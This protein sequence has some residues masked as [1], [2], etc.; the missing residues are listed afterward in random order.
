[1]KPSIPKL[2]QDPDKSWLAWYGALTQKAYKNCQW[3]KKFEITIMNGRFLLLSWGF[4]KAVEQDRS[5]NDQTFIGV[6][7]VALVIGAVMVTLFVLVSAEL[8]GAAHC[9]VLQQLL[10]ATATAASTATATA[11]TAGAYYLREHSAHCC[12]WLLQLSACTT[13]DPHLQH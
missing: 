1:V 4:I 10:L 13:A 2:S 12:L 9:V 11:T 8:A 5:D 7:W 6:A 3:R